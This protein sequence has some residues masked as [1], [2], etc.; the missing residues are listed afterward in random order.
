MEPDKNLH[1][2]IPASLLTE[3]AR[4]AGEQRVTLDE[5]ME[6]AVEHYLD[7]SG[8]KKLYA[9]GAQQAR[10]LGIKEGDVDRIVHEF[11]QEERDS[12]NSENGR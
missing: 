11:R 4:I 3:A 8:W 12:L 10:R 5:W 6:K 7:E 9:Y 1:A 2:S